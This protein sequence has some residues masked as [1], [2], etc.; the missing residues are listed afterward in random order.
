ML[1][2]L[3]A[4]AI[5]AALLGPQPPTRR[6]V[7]E[8][9]AAL[10]VACE[11]AS[12]VAPP[13]RGPPN[14]AFPFGES[15]A[16]MAMCAP[17]QAEAA[18]DAPAV[19]AA[20]PAV[21]ASPAAPPAVGRPF[22]WSGVWN[23]DGPGDAAL[24]KRTGLSASE[25]AAVLAR[26]LSERKYILTGQMSTQV[27]SDECRF[28]DPNNAVTGLAKYR[29]ALSL[30]FDPQQSELSRVTVA[31]AQGRG[32]RVIE[33]DYVASGVLKLPWRPRI[34]AWA[35]HIEYAL[36]DSGLIVSQVD[37]WNITRLDALRQTFTPGGSG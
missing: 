12:A 32:G 7:V 30:L 2:T 28:V 1:S 13:E 14:E 25:V 26:D 6:A 8:G 17:V 36:D 5:A 22:D 10:C 3:G 31:V 4:F 20:P 34:S 35:G 21:A 11:P 19:A 18:A 37:V 29:Q 9:F 24:P 15:D 23:G 27:F 16:L 33:A